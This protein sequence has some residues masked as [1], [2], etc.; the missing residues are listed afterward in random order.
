MNGGSEVLHAANL[1]AVVR[2][3]TGQAAPDRSAASPALSPLKLAIIVG[4]ILL[5]CFLAV[6]VWF[7]N[8]PEP[9]EQVATPAAA[10][11]TPA[12]RDDAARLTPGQSATL[13]D[14]WAKLRLE[15][16]EADG[17]SARVT[18]NDQTSFALQRGQTV[19]VGSGSRL[20]D[21]TLSEASGERATLRATCGPAPARPEAL[22]AIESEPALVTSNSVARFADGALQV[23]VSMLSPSRGALR[24]RINGGQLETLEEG[25][26]ATVYTNDDVCSVMFFGATDGVGRIAA[27]CSGDT[28]R[29]IAAEN[30]IARALAPHRSTRIATGQTASFA[31]EALD[32]YVGPVDARR[33]SARLSVAG[34]VLETVHTGTARLATVDGAPCAVALLAVAA[35]GADI[36]VACAGRTVA[37]P[38]IVGG[39]EAQANSVRT[40]VLPARKALLLGERVRVELSM[41]SPDGQAVRWSINESGLRTTGLGEEARFTVGDGTCA[42]AFLR[43]D[44]TGARVKAACDEAAMSS[45]VLVSAAEQVTE[46]VPNQSARLLGDKLKVGLSMI[47]PDGEAVR[48]ALND[49]ELRT[50]E[51]GRPQVFDYGAGLCSLDF[52]GRSAA[53]AAIL[54]A[55]CDRA[56]LSSDVLVPEA[57]ERAPIPPGTEVR[58]LEGRLLVKLSMIAPDGQAIRFAANGGQLRT[59]ELGQ[60]VRFPSGEGRCELTYLGQEGT[61]ALLRGACDAAAL[62]GSAFVPVRS[63]QVGLAV[64]RTTAL[65]ADRL[66]L[67]LSMISPDR[68]ALRIDANGLGLRTLERGRAVALPVGQGTCQLDYLGYRGSGPVVEA[69]CDAAAFARAAMTPNARITVDLAYRQPV[70]LFDGRLELGLSMISPRGDA[71]R[72]SVNGELETLERGMPTMIVLEGQDCGLV[73]DEAV[74]PDRVRVTVDCGAGSSGAAGPANMEPQ[75]LRVATGETVELF[76]GATS[77]ALTMISPSRTGLRVSIGGEKVRSLDLGLPIA[78]DLAGKACRIEYRG[79]DRTEPVEKALITTVCR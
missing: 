62:A 42:L 50:L 19:Q 15:G 47:A 39:P 7:E 38:V 74:R 27:A 51:R 56:A 48:L 78:L 57:A 16:I 46:L 14:G 3:N 2:D 28:G 76:G 31:D 69:T 34:G 1:P 13:A 52:A 20:C 6:M 10:R 41:V 8:R 72:V 65:M 58:L 66:S 40:V 35:E 24:A 30:E 9:K 18:V 12:P 75:S 36:A 22:P 64:G 61:R 32:V 29:L 54:R 59:A 71:L 21:V 53:G 70:R 37:P 67:T 63:E 26:P 4:S 79:T 60:P 45:R 77:L 68:E 43:V 17:A 11:P 5:T 55:A 33:G 44:G 49:G 23:E 73:Y 25:I